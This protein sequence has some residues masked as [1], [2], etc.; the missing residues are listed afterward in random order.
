MV[1]TVFPH[2]VDALALLD[3]VDAP[4]ERPVLLDADANA[5]TLLPA[6]RLPEPGWD[7]YEPI[8]IKMFNAIYRAHVFSNANKA[9]QRG[10]G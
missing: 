6:Q 2:Y 1:C 4:D 9:D 3:A 8:P 5:D 10:T 7:R